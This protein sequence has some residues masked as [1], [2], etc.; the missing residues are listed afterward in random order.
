[1][2]EHLWRCDHCIW[3]RAYGRVSQHPH[4]GLCTRYAPQDTFPATSEGYRCL[5][6]L[7]NDAT[8]EFVNLQVK[9]RA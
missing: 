3:R 2:N 9:G 4:F 8:Y 1:M 6:Y 7:P 5:E